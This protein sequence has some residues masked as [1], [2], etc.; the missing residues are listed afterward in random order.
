MAGQAPVKVHVEYWRILAQVPS[1]DVTGNKGR[2]RSFEVKIND[3]LVFS[4]LD[5]GSFPDF[6]E[7][8]TRVLEVS[9]GKPVQPI[10]GLQKS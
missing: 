7:V 8:V 5:K 4:K 3:E 9:Q 2:T 6:G 1:A 10:T